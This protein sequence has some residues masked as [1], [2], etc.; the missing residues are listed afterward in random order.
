M[1]LSSSNAFPSQSGN[2]AD[3]WHGRFSCSSGSLKDRFPLLN[4]RVCFGRP[5]VLPRKPKR[6]TTHEEECRRLCD[7]F[8]TCHCRVRRD[9]LVRGQMFMSGRERKRENDQDLM[10]T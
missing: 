2:Q 7:S 3:H 4:D 1:P 10:C 8:T 5:R 9:T 6:W